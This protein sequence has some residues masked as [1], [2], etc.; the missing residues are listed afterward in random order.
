MNVFK[1]EDL[2]KY[3]FTFLRKE[4]KIICYDCSKILFWDKKINH[5]I[6]YNNKNTGIFYLI[7]NGSY[8]MS[9]HSERFNF[10]CNIT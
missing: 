9:C 6:T 1:I 4:P 7:K 3:I 8:C 2:K 10:R 5:F